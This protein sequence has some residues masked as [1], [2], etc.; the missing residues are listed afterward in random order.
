MTLAKRQKPAWTDEQLAR[1]KK[2]Q[3]HIS[4]AGSAAGL[5]SLGLLGASTVAGRKGRKVA[6]KLKNASQNSAIVGAGIGG[7]GGFNFAAI[8]NQEARRA[9]LGKAYDHKELARRQAQADVESAKRKAPA[10]TRSVP[11]VALKRREWQ[12][13]DP[14]RKRQ[15]RQ[16]GYAAAVAGGAV[17]SAGYSGY[18]AGR[19]GAAATKA[20]L[21][22]NNA[23]RMAREAG[24]LR[25]DMNRS[26]E[27]AR[28]IARQK[29]KGSGEESRRY[30]Q[31]GESARNQRVEARANAQALKGVALR[32]AG[33]AKAL[34]RKSALGA[35]A[36]GGLAATAAGIEAHRRKGGASYT[37]WWEHR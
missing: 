7:A 23:R 1:H 22:G 37:G 6:V 27:E 3:A 29:K 33:S 11:K 14:E 12:P 9:K 10:K 8:Q 24:E 19:A 20:R 32:H 36:A 31:L 25:R 18:Q 16:K 28:R 13:Y 26:N 4:Q 21:A 17:G 2:A 15:N 5:T 35:A 34:G 30:Y